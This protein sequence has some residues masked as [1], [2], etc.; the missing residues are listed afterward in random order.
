MWIA[1]CSETLVPA[2]QTALCLSWKAKLLKNFN[3]HKHHMWHCTKSCL[4]KQF[5]WDVVPWG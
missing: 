4:K 3:P 5:V 2:Y 1:G